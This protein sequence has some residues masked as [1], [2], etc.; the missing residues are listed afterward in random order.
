MSKKLPYQFID[1]LVAQARDQ[2]YRNFEE[3]QQQ[4][5]PTGSVIPWAGKDGAPIPTGW[6]LCDGTSYKTA[7]H[8][9]L[10]GTIGYEYGGSGADFNVPNFSDRFP[11]G[12]HLGSEVGDLGGSAT[13]S[14]PSHGHGF[15]AEAPGTGWVSVDHGHYYSTS[16]MHQN[17]SH[18][19]GARTANIIW[20]G[21][22]NH[23]HHGRGGQG[24]EGPWEG[25]NSGSPVPVNVDSTD[26]N[27]YHDGNTN[28]ISANHFHTVNNHGHGFVAQGDGGTNNPPY[29]DMRFI[30]KV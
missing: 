14:M 6:L 13:S 20:N 1:G 10:F 29:I 30:I 25:G 5:V 22:Q 26:I 7:A 24:S 18:W 16:W 17:W 27:H 28:G 23:G 11:R 12:T 3:I 9:Q 15:V 21:T 2:L 8:P 4:L 19:H